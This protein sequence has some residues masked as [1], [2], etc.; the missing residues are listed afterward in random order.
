[1]PDPRYVFLVGAARSGTK[2]LRDTLASSSDIAAVPYDINYVWRHG[3]EDCP[4]DELAPEDVDN[5]TAAHIRKSVRRLAMKAHQGDPKIVL[6]KS[7]SNTLRMDLIRRVFPEAEFIYLE[8]NGLDVV[9]SSY[10]QWTA[11]ADHSYLFEKLRY[12]PLNE[13]RYAL[14]F[15][16]NTLSGTSSAPVWGPRYKGISDDLERLGTAQTCAL[17]WMHSVEHARLSIE[18][19]DTHVVRY[20]QLDDPANGIL[21][22]TSSL[23]LSD[24]QAVSE[25][26]NSRYHRTTTWPGALPPQDLAEIR[27]LV[28][29][30]GS[31]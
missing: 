21:W 10:R 15:A 5:K 6:E 29:A 18:P 23:G 14:W 27:K 30:T 28:G 26:L 9:E 24:C 31:V 11:P 4:H 22:L 2:F 1:M 20:E 19:K 8:R 12:F 7:V 25:A 16:K 3:N 17:Q 13:W